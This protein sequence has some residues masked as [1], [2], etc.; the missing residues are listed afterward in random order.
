M[1]DEFESNNLS[2][3]E[4]RLI[5]EILQ[6]ADINLKQKIDTSIEEFIECIKNNSKRKGIRWDD[7]VLKFEWKFEMTLIKDYLSKKEL[8]EQQ[9]FDI[10]DYLLKHECKADLKTVKN[11]MKERS[12]NERETE[13][14]VIL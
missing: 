4:I 5:E 6:K 14:L 7:I 11:F 2:I 1:V 8:T 10:T 3:E 12:I 9:K 13:I